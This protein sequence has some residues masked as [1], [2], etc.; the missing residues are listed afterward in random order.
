MGWSTIGSCVATCCVIWMNAII[1]ADAAPGTVT[2][3]NVYLSVQ[4]P[5]VALASNRLYVLDPTT[6]LPILLDPE[7]EL[8]CFY[9]VE[10][11]GSFVLTAQYSSCQV[12]R[13]GNLYSL[14]VLISYYLSAENRWVN[15][16]YRVSCNRP[17]ADFISLPEQ[18]GKT[19]CTANYMEMPIGS[20]FLSTQAMGM[21][22]SPI[23][24]VKINTGRSILTMSLN[25]ARANGYEFLNLVSGL[26]VRAHFNS[27]GV[28]KFGRFAPDK[29]LYFSDITLSSTIRT[30]R[31]FIH[32]LMV[33][34]PDP[35]TCNPKNLT[36]EIPVFYG[37]LASLAIGTRQ[38]PLSMKNNFTVVKTSYS[39][40]V[41]VP[42]QYF[43][44]PGTECPASGLLSIPATKLT[45][46]MRGFLIFM[47]FLPLCA[48]TPLTHRN[49]TACNDGYFT[50]QVNANVTQPALNLSTIHLR[51][52]SCHPLVVTPA[53]LL[54]KFPLTSCGTTFKVHGDQLVYENEVSSMIADRPLGVITRDSEFK[55]TVECYQNNAAE[56]V[57]LDT[58]TLAPPS[59]ASNKGNLQLVLRAYPDALYSSPFTVQDYPVVKHL[60]APIYLEVQVLNRQDPNIELVLENCWATAHPDPNS[61]PRWSVITAGCAYAED[62]YPTVMHPM[63][64]FTGIQFPSHYKRF[65]VKAFAFVSKDAPLSN[66]VYFHCTA[67][68]CDQQHPDSA[69]CTEGCQTRAAP[70]GAKEGFHRV[71]AS[72]PDVGAAHASLP[73]PFMVQKQFFR[74]GGNH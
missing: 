35:V 34:I 73:G 54:Y 57:L 27:T 6:S 70:L 33:C 25:Q 12:K 30:Q 60:R 56:T 59:P 72:Y 71:Q 10:S 17:L 48:C 11:V 58:R 24:T 39:L 21:P 1:F 4:L 42:K 15:A 18:L 65:D 32:L 9:S 37:T 26:L 63:S 5:R 38:Y 51:D 40:A 45:F 29:M 53:W 20:I 49:E 13:V 36:I 8:K 50:F 61:R 52:P 74:R 41:T 66:S 44:E 2:C 47:T 68:I 28:Q 64:G 7:Y 69:Y 31:I 22:S 16:T 14:G 62:D 43:L 3:T 67:L 19:N 23:W 46:Q 55:L